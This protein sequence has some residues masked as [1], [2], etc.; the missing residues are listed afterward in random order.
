M[1]GKIAFASIGAIC[2]ALTAQVQ[3][4]SNAPTAPLPVARPAGPGD[5]GRHEPAGADKTAQDNADDDRHEPAFAAASTDGRKNF[6]ALLRRE[7]DKTG[8]PP[9]IA[10]AVVAIESGY[11]PTVIGDVGEIGLM[12]VRPETAAMLGFRGD[13]TELAR[14]EVNIHYGVVYLAEAWRLANGDLCRALMKYRA[15]HGEEQMSPLSATYC[16]RARA[17]LAALGSPFAAAA[18]VPMVFESIQSKAPRAFR[19]ARRGLPR[20]RTAST[21]RAFWAAHEARVAAISRRIEA[22]WRRMASR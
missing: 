13:A 19:T 17:H 20:L 5:A 4:Q 3:A 11:D 12:Q 14:P 6:R 18:S 22:K 16:G 7:A 10:D 8:L 15:G 9:D 21:S 1:A 2:V